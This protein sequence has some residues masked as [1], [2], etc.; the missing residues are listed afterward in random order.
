MECKVVAGSA[1]WICQH[2][3]AAGY[4]LKFGLEGEANER[5]TGGDMPVSEEVHT[6]WAT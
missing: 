1:F 4:A 3:Y 2:A 5:K 6:C